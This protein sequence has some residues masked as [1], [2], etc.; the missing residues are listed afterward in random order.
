MYLYTE[1]Q[2]PPV[3]LKPPNTH[4]DLRAP[5]ALGSSGR[6]PHRPWCKEKNIAV[7]HLHLVTLHLPEK[8]ILL[9]Y[10]VLCKLMGASWGSY[11]TCNNIPQHALKNSQQLVTILLNS[12]FIIWHCRTWSYKPILASFISEINHFQSPLL[13]YQQR[14]SSTLIPGWR[15]CIFSFEN[16][17]PSIAN[18]IRVFE[19]ASTF[20]RIWVNC[21]VLKN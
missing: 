10:K 12:M 13:E 14:S 8:I 6:R 16:L 20:P 17:L 5:C 3:A 11:I 15:R 7:G 9:S 4:Q 19:L 1:G 21:H 18:G 2:R